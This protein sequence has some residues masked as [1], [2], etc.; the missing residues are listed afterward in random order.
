MHKLDHRLAHRSRVWLVHFGA[1]SPCNRIA[2]LPNSIV[3]LS[4]TWLTRPVTMSTSHEVVT[5]G[6]ATS[7]TDHARGTPLRVRGTEF[8]TSYSSS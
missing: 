2:M 3:L 6:T 1:A 4:R 7:A 8:G 5:T